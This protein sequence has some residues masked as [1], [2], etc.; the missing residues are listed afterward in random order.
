MTKATGF[1]LQVAAVIVALVA[2]VPFSYFSIAGYLFSIAIFGMGVVMWRKGN[3]PYCE[4]VTD[5]EI[6]GWDWQ[7]SDAERAFQES[8]EGQTYEEWAA[9]VEKENQ[10]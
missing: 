8:L 10:S 6:E 7:N 5:E 3:K 4:W 9:E 2:S 1:L